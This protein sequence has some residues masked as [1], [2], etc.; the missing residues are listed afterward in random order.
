[1]YEAMMYPSHMTRKRTAGDVA[2]GTCDGSGIH[3]SKVTYRDSEFKVIPKA[4]VVKFDRGGSGFVIKRFPH[5][6]RID[7]RFIIGIIITAC[8]VVCDT[9]SLLP[10]YKFFQCSIDGAGFEALFFT[11]FMKEFNEPMY[12]FTSKHFFV[13]PGDAALLF[14]ISKKKFKLNELK[15]AQPCEIKISDDIIIAGYPVKPENLSYCCP[16]LRKKKG[17]E[18]DRIIRE[19]FHNFE[20]LVYSSGNIVGKSDSLIDIYCAS[21]NGMSGGPIIAN[22]KIVGVYLG[23]PP[24]P[25]QYHLYYINQLVRARDFASAYTTLKATNAET[26][27]FYKRNEFFS[28]LETILFSC[29]A[30]SI[31]LSGFSQYNNI[32][33]FLNDSISMKNTDDSILKEFFEEYLIDVYDSFLLDRASEFHSM[34]SNLFGKERD[35]VIA[36]DYATR[37]IESSQLSKDRFRELQKNLAILVIGEYEINKKEDLPQRITQDIRLFDYLAEYEEHKKSFFLSDLEEEIESFDKIYSDAVYD[38]V[39][40]Y[41][42]PKELRHNT[43]MSVNH[44]IFTRIAEKL[45]A[46]ANIDMPKFTSSDA[47]ISFLQQHG[48]YEDDLLHY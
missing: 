38:M 23:G 4:L 45:E 47:L 32:P 30:L 31:K 43:A 12:S 7:K 28:K 29:A 3:L 27:R 39:I 34:G 37:I 5:P 36:Y 18:R 17:A 10:D 11:S 9:S 2:F 14:L 35:F 21:T 22:N 16:L 13:Y 20:H 46:I 8:H 1:M 24:L 42:K 26:L 41:R 33:E 48:V 19:A 15:I 44:P 40:Q 6:I 25:G